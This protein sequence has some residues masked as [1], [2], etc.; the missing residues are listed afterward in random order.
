MVD[1]LKNAPAALVAGEPGNA[2]QLGPI[3]LD[4]HDLYAGYY[5]DLM[6]VTSAN[7]GQKLV[8]LTV[9]AQGPQRD[10]VVTSHNADGQP[11]TDAQFTVDKSLFIVTEGLTSTE[12]ARELFAI[13]SHGVLTLAQ[14]E[15]GLLGYDVSAQGYQALTGTWEI[16]SEGPRGARTQGKLSPGL[17]IV[18]KIGSILIRKRL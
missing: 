9:Q 7:A 17:Y 1:N 2:S 14:Q 10:L 3:I 6:R 11:V 13:N 4:V 16:T 8:A 15:V 18:K 12:T 5:R